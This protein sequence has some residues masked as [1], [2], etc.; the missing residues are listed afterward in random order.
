MGGKQRIIIIFIHSM[1]Y[2]SVL[3][4]S[5]RHL[6]QVVY[7]R[8]GDKLWLISVFQ[9]KMPPPPH[10]PAQAPFLCQHC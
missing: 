3:T 4:V 5:Q 6:G 8:R 9:Q 1:P 7:M 2:P 10:G